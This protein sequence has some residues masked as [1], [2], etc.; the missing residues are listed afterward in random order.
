VFHGEAFN[1]EEASMVRSL[2]RE[3]FSRRLR[4]VSLCFGGV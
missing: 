3:V 1:E 2:K 4:H